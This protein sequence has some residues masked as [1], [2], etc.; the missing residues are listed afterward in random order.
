MSIS[1]STS[2]FKI[3]IQI[4]KQFCLM[5]CWR[6][7]QHDTDFRGCEV[8][9][10]PPIFEIKSIQHKFDNASPQGKWKFFNSSK[11]IS[12]T[13]PRVN[14]SYNFKWACNLSQILCIYVNFVFCN[15]NLQFPSNPSRV[16]SPSSTRNPSNSTCQFTDW[17]VSSSFTVKFVK[18]L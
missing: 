15:H 14:Q 18:P 13:V 10:W 17:T 5:V 6:S 8:E 7:W 9:L 12:V 11:I 16:Q 2:N 1:T 4:R 3:Q